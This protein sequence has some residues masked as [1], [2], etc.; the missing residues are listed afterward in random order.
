M[1]SPLT[2]LPLLDIKDMP[3]TF[4]EW[5]K[6]VQL[7]PTTQRTVQ[8]PTSTTVDFTSIPSWVKRI[9]VGFVGISTNGN[10]NIL[11][12]LG[13]SGGIESTGYLSGATDGT[14]I[15][16]SSTAGLIVTASW[17]GGAF[18]ANG[19][20]SIVQ[21]NEATNTWTS[22]GVLYFNGGGVC[23]FSGGSKSTSTILDRIRITTTTG[24]DVFDAGTIN[25]SYHS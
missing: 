18:D 7:L 19:T 16:S 2:P 15:S 20:I 13:D 4:Q 14:P 24:V 23:C 12:Q 9:D 5:L 1:S 11:I 3:F 17:N 6:R 10:N 25:I 8:T 21:Q 22:S